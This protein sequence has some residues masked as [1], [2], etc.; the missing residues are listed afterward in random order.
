MT[1][2]FLF[3]LQPDLTAHRAVHLNGLM[4]MRVI[5]WQCNEGR[6]AAVLILLVQLLERL[7]PPQRPRIRSF[8]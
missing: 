1:R 4:P 3:T 6:F 8:F 7:G 5:A 2:V